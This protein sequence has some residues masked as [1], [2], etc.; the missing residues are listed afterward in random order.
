[1]HCQAVSGN[2]RLTPMFRSRQDQPTRACSK[3]LR[4]GTVRPDAGD[5]SLR[6]GQEMPIPSWVVWIDL[7]PIRTTERTQNRRLLNRM[8]AHVHAVLVG[9][10]VVHVVRDCAVHAPQKTHAPLTV[11]V[12]SGPLRSAEIA[13]RTASICKGAGR[14]VGSL[15]FAK[16]RV[17]GSNPVV[18][19]RR[20]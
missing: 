9:V 15:L 2:R 10:F 4:Q 11:K 16:V 18:R 8:G 6:L 14:G 20:P 19:S 13:D 5:E 1:V 3:I 12:N 17:A 7:R